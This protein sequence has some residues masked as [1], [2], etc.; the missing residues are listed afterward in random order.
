MLHL[1]IKAEINLQV[2]SRDFLSKYTET[3]AKFDQR[4]QRV[5]KSDCLWEK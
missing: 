5:A 2:D 4:W 1:T 3:G